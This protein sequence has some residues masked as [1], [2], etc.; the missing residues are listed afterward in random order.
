MHNKKANNNK[1]TAF[2]QGLRPLSSSFPRGLKKLLRKGGYN[3]SNIPPSSS[4]LCNN[5]PEFDSYPPLALCLGTDIE[6]SSG[7]KRFV[8][9]LGVL[10]SLICL[11]R[12]KSLTVNMSAILRVSNF[13]RRGMVWELVPDPVRARIAFFC[14]LVRFPGDLPHRAIP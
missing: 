2:I 13:L 14:I 10:L 6:S 7:L 12:H 11:Y 8:I 5:S 9:R 3:F 4:A 1:S